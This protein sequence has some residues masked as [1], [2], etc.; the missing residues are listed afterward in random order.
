[1]FFLLTDAIIFFSRFFFALIACSLVRDFH[2]DLE[3][4]TILGYLYMN[5]LQHVVGN[6]QRY[7][8]GTS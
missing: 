8:G 1:M 7:L 3:H 4:F 6:T 5:T 2:S